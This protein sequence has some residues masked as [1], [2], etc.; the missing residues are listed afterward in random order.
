MP[1]LHT[2]KGLALALIPLLAVSNTF[3]VFHSKD[4]HTRHSAQCAS[5]Q[6]L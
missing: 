1:S 6:V 4:F 5:R 2:D 3:C